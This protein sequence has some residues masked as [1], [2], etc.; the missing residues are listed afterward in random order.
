MTPLPS[1]HAAGDSR[2]AIVSTRLLRAIADLRW[3]ILV[4]K[5]AL[6]LHRRYDPNQPRVPAGS[7][8]GGPWTSGG[9]ASPREMIR[10]RGTPL[11]EATPAQLSTIASLRARIEAAAARIRERDPTWRKPESV[12]ATVEGQIK[13]LRAV[14]TEAEAHQAHLIRWGLRG[15]GRFAVE[16]IPASVDRRLDRPER[17]RLQFL[18]NRDG[19]HTCGERHP[20]GIFARWFGDHQFNNALNP[21]GRP[22]EIFPQ[23]VACSAV[24]GGY[25][26]AMKAR[27]GR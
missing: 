25:V 23:C 14:A 10:R 1:W 13:H 17:D 22:Q 2:R 4:L 21:S 3:D 8:D 6:G 12:T 27:E 24:Q 19:C 20:G 7:P 5:T 16:S 15:P 9:G 26:R 18:G 11:S